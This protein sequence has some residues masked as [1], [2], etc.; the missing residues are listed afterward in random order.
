MPN[1][2]LVV[3][4]LGRVL[5]RIADDWDHAAR[6]AGLPE[7]SGLIGDISTRA[8]RGS[9]HPLADLFDRFETGRISVVEFFASAARLAEVRPSEVQRVMDAVLI[10]TF[11]GV[12]ALLDRLALSP[13]NTAC[14]S[15]TNA[16]HWVRITDRA[17][18]AYIPLE[19]LDYPLASHIVGHAKPAPAIYQY[20]ED[21]TGIA[22]EGI[23]FFDDL[24][25]NINAATQR[26]WNAVLVQRCDNPVPALR[27]ELQRHGVL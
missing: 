20:L 24:P 22:P 8:A 10:E 6:L 18:R 11:P 5:L 27:L 16:H 17:H 14:L 26:G 23:L 25:E 12:I 19:L 3:F 13:V 15:N 9:G 21:G 2:Q 1:I 7:L 4:D